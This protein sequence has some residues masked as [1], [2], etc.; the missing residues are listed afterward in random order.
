MR[1]RIRQGMAAA[2]TF[3]A[4][5]VSGCGWF[6]N[7]AEPPPSPP[8]AL[9]DE[10]PPKNLAAFAEAHR[11]GLGYMERYNYH[12]ARDAFLKAHELAPGSIAATINLAIA[13]LNDTG[14]QE[15]KKKKEGGEISLSKFDSAIALL[16]EV[17][18]RD[19]D[20]LFAHYCRGVILQFVSEF[21]KANA[22]FRFVTEHDPSD[23][24]S[25][26]RMGETTTDPDTGMAPKKNQA[27]ELVRIYSEALKRNPYD[28]NANYRLAM[29]FGLDGQRN[30]QDEYFKLFYSL[31]PE[32]HPKAPG[33]EGRLTYGQ[34]GK[35]A[36]IIDPFT[37]APSAA[38]KAVPPRF[39]PPRAIEVALPDGDRWARA[40]DFVEGLAVLGRARARFGAA[41]AAFDADGDDKIDLYLAAAV[42]G[43]KGVRDAL[44][45]NKGDGKFEDASGRFG[46]P[47]D[48]ASL[49]VAAGDFDADR[50]VDLFVTGIGTHR[51]LRNEAG[52][53]FA[54]VSIDLAAM[55]P[56]AISP[57]ARWMDLDQDGDLDLYIV[58]YAP[59]N[60]ADAF[61]GSASPG[62]QNSAYRNDGVPPIPENY[63]GPTDALAPVAV[64][65][66]SPEEGAGLT[67]KFT[68][69]NTPEAAPLLGEP[70]A[71][72]GVAVLDLDNDRDLDLVLTADGKPASAI[73]N[74][75]LGRFHAAAVS[76]LD[77][78]DTTSG[79][80][81]IDLDEDGRSD[82]VAPSAKGPVAARRNVSTRN[83]E[84]EV[85]LAFESFPID[86]R[87]WRSAGVADVDLDG[88]LDLLALPSS[89]AP[90]SPIFA[91][92]EVER[93][94]ASPL[95]LG[96]VGASPLRG[97]AYADLIGDSL[98]DVVLVQDGEA[99]KLAT[100]RGNGH[101]WL[102][103]EI[104][105][106]WDVKP[107][108]MRTN[109][110]GLG[111]RIVIE[112]DGLRVPFDYTTIDSGSAQS[113]VPIILGLGTLQK[114]RLVRVK[115]PD[116]VLQCELDE[117]A[118]RL[119]PLIENNRKEGSCPVLFTWNG[120]RM[121]C[122][123]DFL[124]GGGLGYL[125]APGEYGQPD[126]DESVAIASDQLRVVN[127]AYRMAIAE[128]MSEL[129]YL[130]KLTLDVVDRPPGVTAGLD[131]R[132]A[133]G[134]NRPSGALIAWEEPVEFAR[135][136][137]F[138]GREISES[139]R[140][141]DR[142]YGD[143]FKRVKGW[144]GYAEDHGIVLD[145]GDRLSRFG[146]EDRLALILD[147]YTEYPYSQTNY[148]A[149]TAGV[150]LRPPVLERLQADGSWKVLEGDP[151]YPAGMQR[152]TSL[153]LTG[154]LGGPSCVL[155]LV[156]NM[157]IGW[158]RAFVAPLIADAG[159][160]VTSIAVGAASLSHRGYI[161][162]VSPDGRLP[163]IYDYEYVDPAPLATLEGR[164]TRFGDVTPLLRDDDDQLCVVG[165]GDDVRLEFPS[166]EVPSLTEGWTRSYVL[167]SSGYCKDADPFTAGSDEVGPLPWQGMPAFPFGRE[168]ERPRDPAYDTYLKEYQTR[169]VA[170]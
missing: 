10:I 131:E 22:D 26:V 149:S 95:P 117:D 116:G 48:L 107:K 152:A 38:R 33:D 144:I 87:G 41:V 61:G 153:E 18:E 66:G 121:A 125:V 141:S 120:S 81:V 60:F 170:R 59:A 161:R 27:K 164:L 63:G 79:L 8:A 92:G 49:A 86:G 137:D 100:N 64:A 109:V 123:G 150:P 111:A 94:A 15:E 62:L 24:P 140:R 50:F 159:M 55:G 69:W 83:D 25:W 165:P 40:E 93:L 45:I 9:K 51:L 114:A 23:A 89:D 139:L 148:A 104:G 70:A 143:D 44:L 2:A 78:P 157:E 129:A 136:T 42:K 124:G 168:G 32:K 145:F 31:D 105:G 162:E 46:L 133:P 77:E 21:E 134:G 39:D 68:P 5:L 14:T 54:D 53:T 84:G 58:N 29:T 80:L 154:K 142:V 122:L 151:G 155:R 37:K 11:E 147:G 126:R 19:P 96:P 17:L 67:R 112:G 35:Y 163:L 20:N 169:S 72:S 74:D 71:H 30:K 97:L 91:R 43:P 85:S 73:L 28:V 127:G 57:I 113:V 36:T 130:D 115:W 167:R 102:G 119:M 47:D 65:K 6:S 106:R 135:A 34:M 132:F 90:P 88:T 98:P 12:A 146:P 156:T 166:S 101:H 82:L 118:D 13:T 110:E 3:C 103:L 99:P 75:R 158:D 128:P 7:P 108:T 138:N 16:T 56:P 4:L 76:G 52:K 1:A 160:R